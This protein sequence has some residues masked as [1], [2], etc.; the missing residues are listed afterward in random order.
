MISRSSSSM[1]VAHPLCSRSLR[2]TSRRCCREYLR[3]LRPHGYCEGGLAGAVAQRVDPAIHR[4]RGHR[5]EP[6]DYIHRED[7]AGWLLSVLQDLVT[8]LGWLRRAGLQFEAVEPL[9]RAPAVMHPRHG[10]LARVAALIK[11]DGPLQRFLRL[12]GEVL[13]CD[14]GAEAGSAGRYPGGLE[15]VV[16]GGRGA[17]SDNVLAD[18]T[19]GVRRSDEVVAA[20][21]YRDAHDENRS[22]ADL[23]PHSL[24]F[25]EVGV[26]E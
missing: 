20:N 8:G 4:K 18:G 23:C 1:P 10:L 11:A 12:A 14:V 3:V 25:G 26:S 7:M 17:C 6:A 22:A 16:A 9:V 5:S 19:K 21:G 15:S 2:G 24:M 13:G